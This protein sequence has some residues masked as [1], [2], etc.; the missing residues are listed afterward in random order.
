M[1]AGA[2]HAVLIAQIPLQAVDPLFVLALVA[3]DLDVA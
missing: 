2:V 3:M 1:D